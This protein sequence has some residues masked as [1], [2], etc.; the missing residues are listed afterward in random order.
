M[1][2][3]TAVYSLSL[4]LSLSLYAWPSTGRSALNSD[5]S[6]ATLQAS[7]GESPVLVVTCSTQHFRGRPGC[8]LRVSNTPEPCRTW[9]RDAELGGQEQPD[10]YA[11]RGQ[12]LIRL[13]FIY[14]RQL[15]EGGDFHGRLRCS[16]KQTSSQIMAC[17]VDATRR[18]WLNWTAVL[19]LLQ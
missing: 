19:C 10:P 9:L 18:D 11:W 4:S 13:S 2:R 14:G 16:Q 3:Y 12:R 8:L 1:T 15:W 6:V 17:H 5:R 7:E